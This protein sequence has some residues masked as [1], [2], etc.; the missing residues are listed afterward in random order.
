[1]RDKKRGRNDC[2][3]LRATRHDSPRPKPLGVSLLHTQRLLWW[4]SG[5]LSITTLLFCGAQLEGRTRRKGRVGVSSP[6]VAWNFNAMAGK[7]R[8]VGYSR[9]PPN[10]KRSKFS[11]SDGTRPAPAHSEWA[12]RSSNDKLSRHPNKNRGSRF[13]QGEIQ[14]H[15]VLCSPC[16]TI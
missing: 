7:R 6:P 1:M 2:V 13:K 10:H 12:Q 11:K 9:T 5:Y 16:W 3:R 8:D 14:F 15:T 4:P